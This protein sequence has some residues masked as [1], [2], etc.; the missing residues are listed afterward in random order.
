MLHR[1]HCTLTQE[2]IS[3]KILPSDVI[4]K[5]FSN[6]ENIQELHTDIYSQLNEKISDI[7]LVSSIEFCISEIFSSNVNMLF[8]SFFPYYLLISC[9]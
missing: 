3:D 9:F 7:R 4:S 5:I 2:N 6:I 1:Y 8:L